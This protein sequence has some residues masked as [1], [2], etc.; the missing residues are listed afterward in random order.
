MPI[1]FIL[2]STVLYEMGINRRKGVIMIT[3]KID[4]YNKEKSARKLETF[5]FFKNNNK[6]NNARHVF[7]YYFKNIENINLVSCVYNL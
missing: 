2:H 6:M 7:N 1:I 5:I 4:I 3:S